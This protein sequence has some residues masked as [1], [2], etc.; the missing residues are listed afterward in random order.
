MKKD[1]AKMK[2]GRRFILTNV[3][4]EQSFSKYQPDTTVKDGKEYRRF[5]VIITSIK[6][7]GDYL[8]VGYEPINKAHGR[9]GYCRIYKEN[10][11]YEYGM[12]GA[13]AKYNYQEVEENV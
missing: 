7:S 10:E 1:I 11:P 3:M 9:F 12:L 2:I 6:D 4:R 5:E 13:E 8:Y